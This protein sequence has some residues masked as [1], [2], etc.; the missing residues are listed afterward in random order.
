MQKGWAPKITLYESSRW[1]LYYQ[2]NAFQPWFSIKTSK[3]DLEN[4]QNSHFYP[5]RGVLGGQPIKAKVSGTSKYIIVT[6]FNYMHIIEKLVFIQH[7][8]HRALGTYHLLYQNLKILRNIDFW[9]SLSSYMLNSMV[10]FKNP[11]VSMFLSSDIK[12]VFF[13][14]KW[15]GKMPHKWY[16]GQIIKNIPNQTILHEFAR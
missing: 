15:V 13:N 8:T 2:K 7:L 6:L 9:N 12:F 16:F 3:N 1:S 14:K 5:F 11:Y 10:S 4:G